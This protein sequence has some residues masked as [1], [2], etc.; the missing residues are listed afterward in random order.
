M[1]MSVEKRKELALTMENIDSELKL[2]EKDKQTLYKITKYIRDFGFCEYELESIR[3]ELIGMAQEAELA[4]ESLSDRI[5]NDVRKFSDELIYAALGCEPPK[6]R[7]FLKIAGVLLEI[8]GILENFVAVIV[9]L[10]LLLFGAGDVMEMLDW[11]IHPGI[12]L[13]AILG[14]AALNILAGRTGRKHC[15][16]VKLAKRCLIYGIILSTIALLN[17]CFTITQGN[18]L[19]LDKEVPIDVLLWIV[20]MTAPFLYT[21]GAKKN[22]SAKK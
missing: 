20:S 1:K 13:A 6:G 12:C 16:D 2:N 8:E 10:C 5:G 18:V 7:I 3:K 14:F 21:I 11:R 19:G 15:A 22:L 9:L 17:L 4:N